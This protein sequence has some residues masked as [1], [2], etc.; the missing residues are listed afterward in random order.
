MGEGRAIYRSKQPR[1][2]HGM[3]LADKILYIAS[4]VGLPADG[5]WTFP[6]TVFNEAMPLVLAQMA[7]RES[8]LLLC[9]FVYNATHIS[10]I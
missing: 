9:G 4:R 10:C 3:T 7:V 6:Q 1:V 2:T 8:H 5:S